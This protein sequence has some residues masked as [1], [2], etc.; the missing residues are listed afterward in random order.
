MKI[1]VCS[2]K[3]PRKK[4]IKKNKKFYLPVLLLLLILLLPLPIDLLALYEAQFN[5]IILKNLIFL[6]F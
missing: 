4:K 3:F 5:L 2:E 1:T 6:K